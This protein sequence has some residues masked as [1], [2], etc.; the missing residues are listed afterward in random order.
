M[1][2]KRISADSHIDLCWMPPD[3]F[4]SEARQGL[5]ERM[6]YVTDGPDGPYWTCKN[7]ISFGLKN[8]V[9]P[10]GQKYEKGKHARADLMADTG[11]YEDGKRGVQRIS[12]PHLRIKD[13]VKT[14]SR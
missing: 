12:D 14:L 13:I 9:G 10:A 5:K 8:G 1:E 7:G 2:Y 11:L 4:V 3:I 6:P